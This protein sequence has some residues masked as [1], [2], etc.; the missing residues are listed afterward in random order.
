LSIFLDFISDK[1]YGKGLNTFRF[2]I[3][4]EENVNVGRHFDGFF[5]DGVQ[6]SIH[7]DKSI[8]HK[9]DEH[10]KVKLIL[11]CALVLIRYMSTRMSLPKDFLVEK[12]ADDYA[13]YL[14]KKKLII[15][16]SEF[17]KLIIKPF[18]TTRFQFIVTKTQQVK[19]DD[20]HYDLIEIQDFINNKITGQTFGTSI[21]HFSLGYQIFDFNEPFFFKQNADFR[22]YR[23]KN[24]EL[25][26]VKHFNYAEMKKLDGSQ[27][28]KFIKDKVLEAIADVDKLL[29]KPKDF[30]KEAFYNSMEN[31]LSEYIEKTWH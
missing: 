3:Y 26:I 21:R 5:K 10:E 8:F 9:S 30:N 17:N 15:D 16:E 11:N 14:R 22:T 6:L 29:R 23:P 24:K 20:L 12:L 25:T 18:D 7:L 2:D 1:N 28:V 13:K 31:I 4:I 27:Q 19:D